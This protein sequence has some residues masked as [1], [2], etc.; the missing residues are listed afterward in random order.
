MPEHSHQ[1]NRPRAGADFLERWEQLR[2][3]MDALRVTKSL[4]E[5]VNALETLRE[6]VGPGEAR[7]V[8]DA[9]ILRVE[10]LLTAEVEFD[11]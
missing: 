2:V 8:A 11:A 7:D 10:E 5:A 4:R 6:L 1:S 9:A 3:N